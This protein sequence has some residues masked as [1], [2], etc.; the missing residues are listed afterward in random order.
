M[1]DLFV[2]FDPREAAAYHVFCQSV[3][4]RTTVPVRFI[5]LHEP[6][7]Q[8]D[9][10]Q[11]GSNAFLMDYQGWALFCD[12][13][14]VAERDLVDLWAL[15]DDRYAV[16]VV[17]HDYKPA[18]KTKYVGSPLE[19]PN[20]AYPRKNW[21][22]VMLWNCSHPSNQAL[23]WSVVANAGGKYLHRFE[24]LEDREIGELPDHWNR[25]VGEEV[26]S[27]SLLHYTLGVPGFRHYARDEYAGPWHETLLDALEIAGESPRETVERAYACRNL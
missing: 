17:K 21:S 9:G 10:Q 3:L 15:R 1:M 18:T 27:G 26:G 20:A 11:D 13:D 14:M 8:F 24:W 4:K 2:G 6:M 23:T 25:L 22:S 16:Q 12:G 5:P 7:L 19:C